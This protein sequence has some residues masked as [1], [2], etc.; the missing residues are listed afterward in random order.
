M[1]R[2]LATST[3]FLVGSQAMYNGGLAVEFALIVSWF[4]DTSQG[5]YS[6]A[7][8][9]ASLFEVGV[10]WG[11]QHLVNREAAARFDTLKERLPSLF[12]ASLLTILCVG[13]AITGV[14]GWP[15][16]V[17]A[18]AALTRAGAMLLGAICIGRGEILAPVTARILSPVLALGVMLVWVRNDPTLVGLALVT[19]AATLGYAGPVWVATQKLG[20]RGPA[21]PSR[22]IS[23]W[24]QLAGD[25]WPYLVLFFFGQL[26]F[27]SDS[28]LLKWLADEAHVAHYMRAFK[29]IEG[30]FFLPHVVA[31]A[32]IP[33][34]VAAGD[35]DDPKAQKRTLLQVAVVLGCALSLVAVGLHLLGPAIL[36]LFLGEAVADSRALFVTLVWVVP[37]HGLGI[38]LAAALVTRRQERALLGIVVVASLCGLTA[39]VI[40]FAL[41]GTTAFVWGLYLGLLVHVLGCAWCLWRRLDS[42]A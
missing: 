4:D 18:V 24:R 14:Y 22:W 13:T 23:G 1:S 31:S 32:A 28:V 26:L 40:G 27:R 7:L 38:Y 25:V 8:G 12:A 33:A 30:L 11:S 6:I 37:I 35:S 19:V 17:I 21:R 10:H 2:R 15:M 20:L 16:A 5:S 36:S 42:P 39:K 29:W 3:L 41:M 9:L 34:L